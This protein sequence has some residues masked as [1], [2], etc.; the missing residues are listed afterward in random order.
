MSGPFPGNFPTAP[1][2]EPWEQSAQRER[3][4]ALRRALNQ[5]PEPLRLAIVLRDME[6]LS[7]EEI[8]AACG[9]TVS[10]VK[11]RLHRG[12]AESRE[13]LRGLGHGM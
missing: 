5:L 3:Q 9:Q 10:A 13:R 7:Y 11:S 6:G 8:A 1:G 12:R 2:L 4:A